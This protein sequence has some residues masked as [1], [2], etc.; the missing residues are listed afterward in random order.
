[1]NDLSVL[2]TELQ[3]LRRRRAALAWLAALAGVLAIA[4]GGLL[5]AFFLDV[6]MHLGIVERLVVLVAWLLATAWAVWRFVWPLTRRRESLLG[7]A[8]MV[9]Q[10][11]GIRS[12]LVAALQFSDANRRQYGLAELRGAVVADTADLSKEL[13]YQVPG[14]SRAMRRNLLAASGA[15]LSAVL[16]IV[17]AGEHV[18]AFADRFLLGGATFPTKTRIRVVSPG[19]RVAYGQPIQFRVMVDGER[20]PHGQVRLVSAV[21][22]DVAS[23]SLLPDKQ[24]AS[25]YVGQMRR[26]FEDCSYVVE[27]GDASVGPRTLTVIPLPKV[28]VAMQIDPPPYAAGRLGKTSASAPQDIALVGSR[29]VPVVTADKKLRSATIRINGKTFPMQPKDG[30]FVLESDVAMLTRVATTLRYEVEVEDV[31]GLRLERP[32]SGVLRVREDRPPHISGQTATRQVLAGA[33]PAVRY[34]ATDDFGIHRVVLRRT[35]LRRDTSGGQDEPPPT[36]VLESSGTYPLQITR[37]LTVPL[38]DLK[39]AVGDRVVCTLQAVD[40]RGA[41]QGK[42]AQS[43]PLVFEVTD[44]VTL[45]KGL[46]EADAKIDRELQGVIRAESGIKE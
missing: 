8:L 22:G 25:V 35:V 12:E 39:L 10:Q 31:D 21:S 18:R 38:S 7:L 17:L 44:R 2:K 26:A 1:M 43:E 37:G 36:P 29:V 4:L 30:R 41:G 42:V 34:V 40:Y 20:P 5:A 45:M 9:E 23:V 15:V 46:N 28:T 16:V 14:S 32:V 6:A 33:S 13:D 24:D 27:V 3:G 19:D 11:Q